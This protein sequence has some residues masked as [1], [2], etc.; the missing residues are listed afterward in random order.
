MAQ[1]ALDYRSIVSLCRTSS[2]ARV[3][4][5]FQKTQKL[6]AAAVKPD[7]EPIFNNAKLNSSIILKARLSASERALFQESRF[8][9]T[10]IFILY[11]ERDL[12]VGGKS[13]FIN[14]ITFY[15]LLQDNFGIDYYA[16]DVAARTDL[17]ALNLI[18]RSPA[19]DPFLL[20]ERL[21]MAGRNVSPD[22]FDISNGDYLRIKDFVVQELK[23][24]AELSA[25]N[26]YEAARFANVIAEKLWDGAD[27]ATLRPLLRS[28]EI[29]EEDAPETLFAW[30]GLIYYK[31]TLQGLAERF[32]GMRRDFGR[33]KLVKYGEAK[34][35]ETIEALKAD[36]L[37]MLADNLRTGQQALARYDEIYHQQFLGRQDAAALKDFLR[38]AP[39][40]FNSIGPSISAV[41][42]AVSYWTYRFRGDRILVCEASEFEDI[43]MDFVEGSRAG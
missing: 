27:T 25:E 12:R 35:R 16:D 34:D 36:V 42:H 13:L 4:N 14:E 41:S 23:P 5:L 15:D 38:D 6:R 1:D 40:I 43:L 20:R 21:R 39:A 31:F 22:Y 8:Q 7:G 17:E 29:A 2:S 37:D 9:G 11:D 32:T 19:L 28:V 26:D 33:L 10:K 3:L 30:K 24:L 18:E